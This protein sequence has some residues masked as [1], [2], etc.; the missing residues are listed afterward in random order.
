VRRSKRPKRR[1][2]GGERVAQEI[3][4][5]PR[6]VDAGGGLMPAKAEECARAARKSVVEG[7]ARRPAHR[8]A[9]RR[10]AA[11]DHASD[12][13]RRLAEARRETTGDD[14]HDALMPRRLPEH[15][16]GQRRQRRVGQRFHRVRE[17]GSIERLS[18]FGH[19]FDLDGEGARFVEGLGEQEAEREIRLRESAG[20]VDARRVPVGHVFRRQRIARSLSR[21]L[22]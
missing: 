14:A 9:P 22:G 17:K 19:A 18:L 4:L 8:S 7:E 6:D 16:D 21:S 13:D 10:A 15:D 11:A 2:G 3:E 1:T 20:C 12:D 5:V